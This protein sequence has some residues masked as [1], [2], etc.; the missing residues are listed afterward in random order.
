[1][2]VSGI[3]YEVNWRKF[4]RGASMFFPCLDAQ[5]A[6]REVLAVTRRL[7]IKTVSKAVIVDGIRGLRIWR[8]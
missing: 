7:R 4:K 2:R 8:V 1:M 5:T 3:N 6:K